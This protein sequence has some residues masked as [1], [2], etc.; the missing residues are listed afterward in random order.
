[1][2]FLRNTWYAAAWTWELSGE[3][4]LPRR[5]LD[6]PVL[7]LRDAQ[8]RARALADRCPHRFAPMSMGRR[9]PAQAA[10]PGQ[11]DQPDLPE[12]LQC[13]YHG[14]Q[15]SLDGQ[16][17]HNPRGAV[18]K[19]AAL[20][21][22]PVVERHSTVWIWMGD[23]ALADAGRIPD[24]S[25][26]DADAN[27]VAGDSMVVQAPYELETDNILDL[28]HIEFMHPLFSS[29]GVSAAPVRCE[30]D[31]H[32]VWS[33][34]FI[35]QDDPPAFLREAF[36]VP[37]GQPCDRWL[38]VRWNAPACLALWSGGVRSGQ[39]RSQGRE[40]AGAH[41]F[42]P[43]TAHSTHYFFGSGLPLQAGPEGAQVVR[44]AVAVGASLDGPF[45]A[46]DKPM[47]EAVARNMGS[48]EFWSLKPVLLA[49]DAAAVRARRL[50]AQLIA[51]EASAQQD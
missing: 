8:G 2:Q 27:H 15:F 14:L 25:F 22:Y 45:H 32:T 23:P 41:L 20:H 48:A 6:E 17:V 51:A 33:R 28:S 7:L 9:L 29:P 38:D 40:I 3:R 50:M 43:E 21:R 44:D 47:I 31:G 12:R 26:M 39:P 13:G 4:C 11:P 35:A 19:A 36:G 24:F 42:T 5:L 37:A 30:L 46:E 1:M 49:G 18:P 34:R 16:C 10:V